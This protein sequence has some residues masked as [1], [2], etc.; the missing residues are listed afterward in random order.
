MV[1]EKCSSKV[2]RERWKALGYLTKG[3]KGFD[4]SFWRIVLFLNFS[5]K[6]WEFLKDNGDIHRSYISLHAFR[7]LTPEDKVLT[8]YAF[9]FL[10]VVVAFGWS[11]NHGKASRGVSY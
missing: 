6:G 2:Y 10:F 8:G 3:R 9:I 1:T 5:I 4:L 11:P 7:R